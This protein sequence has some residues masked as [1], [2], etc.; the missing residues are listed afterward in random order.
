MQDELIQF[1]LNVVWEL[2]KRPDHRIHNV[3]GTKWIFRNK[4][5]EDD[6]S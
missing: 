4:L 3:I 6:K 2:V 1:K 5:D